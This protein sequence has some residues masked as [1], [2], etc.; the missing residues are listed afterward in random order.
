MTLLHSLSAYSGPILHSLSAIL[1]SDFQIGD[2]T[3]EVG[4]RSKGA[5][6]V[7]DA[8][9]GFVVKDDIEYGHGNVIPLWTFGLNY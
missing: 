4:G 9:Q 8:A 2:A 1:I 7:R 3:F 5:K 6:Q